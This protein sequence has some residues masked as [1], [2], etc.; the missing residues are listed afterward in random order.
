MISLLNHEIAPSL[1]CQ[2]VGNPV[3][4]S[5]GKLLVRVTGLLMFDSVRFLR[6]PLR[7]DINRD[8]HPV[9][10]MEYY[11]E[12]GKLAALIGALKG[13]R[14]FTFRRLSKPR[15]RYCYP[16]WVFVGS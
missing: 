12:G 10:K 4:V 6:D 2:T 9:L 11:P 14:L 13:Q 1:R 3:S 8:I 16:M 15:F 5:H 7:R